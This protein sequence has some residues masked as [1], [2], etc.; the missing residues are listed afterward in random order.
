M[1][2]RRRADSHGR[3]MSHEFVDRMHEELGNPLGVIVATMKAPLERFDQADERE[4]KA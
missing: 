1:P 3:A 4:D 2:R